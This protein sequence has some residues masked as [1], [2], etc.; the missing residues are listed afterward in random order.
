MSDRR[1]AVRWIAVTLPLAALA[2][3]LYVFAEWLF[4]VTKPSPTASLPF[5]TEVAVLAAAPLPLLLPLLGIQLAASLL[6]AFAYPRL[7]GLAAVPSAAVAGVLMFLMAD[8]FTYTL[9]GVGA[10]NAGGALRVGY[11]A[12]LLVLVAGAGW[13][14][15]QA[16]D[17]VVRRRGAAPATAAASPTTTSRMSRP[18]SVFPATS[19]ETRSDAASSA[20]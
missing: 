2:A 16:L 10:V 20:R 14:V 12:L 1:A 13:K 17:A 7:R 8:N 18:S 3:I 11:A 4:V 5:T 6:S 19:T 9:F 15:S